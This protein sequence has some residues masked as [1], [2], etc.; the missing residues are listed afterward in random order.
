MVEGRSEDK[1]MN[2]RAFLL[3]VIAAS[4][5]PKSRETWLTMEISKP[6]VRNKK[7]FKCSKEILCTRPAALLKQEY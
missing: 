6:G 4:L 5:A 2:R 7:K 1:E 3:S